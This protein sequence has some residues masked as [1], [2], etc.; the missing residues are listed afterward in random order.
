[1]SI[2]L[3]AIGAIV[4]VAVTVANTLAV[5][6]L[7]I[8]GLK[9]IGNILVSL[10]KALGLIKSEIKIEELGDK[11]IQSGY[12]PEDYNSYSEYIK[13]VE[14]FE[15]DPEKSKLIPEEDKIKKG[16]ELSAGI[17]IEKFDEFPIQEFCIAV[18]KN[19]NYFTE[20]KITEIGKLIKMDGQYIPKILNYINGNEKN[21]EKIKDIVGTL[22]SI[23]KKVNSSISDKDALKNVLQL[24]K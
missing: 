18:G 21:T 22:T 20:A 23:E 3:G 17:I 11:A 6:G 24:K 14:N 13:A 7:A 16:M 15:L 9:Q 4:K 5:T 8:N 2:I 19:P 10:G 12:K 1:M